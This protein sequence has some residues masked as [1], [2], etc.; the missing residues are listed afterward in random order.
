MYIQINSISSLEHLIKDK[1]IKFYYMDRLGIRE[2]TRVELYRM[3]L[4]EVL[5]SIN[6]KELL[7]ES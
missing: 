6:N 7:F 5:K 2:F 4:H 3:T 1:D